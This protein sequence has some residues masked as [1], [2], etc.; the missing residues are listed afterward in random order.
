MRFINLIILSLCISTFSLSAQ[1]DNEAANLLEKVSNKYKEY[2]TSK[3]VVLLTLDIPESDK[4][5]VKEATAWLKKDKFKIEFDDKILMSDTESQWM[6]LKEENELQISN[7]DESAM[8]FLPSKILNIYSENYIYKIKE[9]YKNSKGELI[10]KIELT[11]KNK[12]MEIFKIVVSINTSTMEV[13]ETKMFEKSGFRYSY[14][15][16]SLKTNMTL[17][18]SFFV[19]D[20]SKFKIDA[21]D[22]TDLR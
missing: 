3:I 14:K 18:D 7:Y 9:E 16:L 13:L 10:K 5:V 20:V 6:F 2:K 12:E 11:P 15:I 21:D 22:V 4:D 17:E 1:N 8:V 19:F